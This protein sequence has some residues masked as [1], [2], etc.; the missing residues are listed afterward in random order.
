M[1]F[2]DDMLCSY[3][4]RMDDVNVSIVCMFSIFGIIVRII[5]TYIYIYVIYIYNITN[6]FIWGTNPYLSHFISV[7]GKH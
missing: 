7:W 4:I 3:F 1:Q 2:N 6:P 5:Y